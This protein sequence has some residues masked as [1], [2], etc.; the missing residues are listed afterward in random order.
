MTDEAITDSAGLNGPVSE[1]AT[2]RKRSVGTR[3]TK[4][5]AEKAP[6]DNVAIAEQIGEV[7]TNVI[8]SPQAAHTDGPVSNTAT[9]VTG[10]I[11]SKAADRVFE[12]PV[13]KPLKED[14]SNKVA[15]WS[16][17]NVRWSGVGTMTKGYNI[18][19]KEAAVKWLSREGVRKATPEEVA[20]HY[21]K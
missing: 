17:K 4:K 6:V 21:G 16:D 11:G 12:K 14:L 3:A 1:K 10:V 9:S 20:T 2:P 13:Q 19:N 5:V 18:V 8:S 15:L 7:E